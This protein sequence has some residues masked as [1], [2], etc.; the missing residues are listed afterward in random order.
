MILGAGFGT[1]LRPL[2]GQL[3]KPLVPVLNRPLIAYTV[4]KLQAIG[5]SEIVVNL[6]YRGEKLRDYLLSQP[7]DIQFHFSY[8][9]EKILGTAGGLKAAETYLS[10]EEN[11]LLINGDIFFDFDLEEAIKF[12][13]D[14]RAIATLILS[15]YDS[16]KGDF[17]G[18]DSRGKVVRVPGF[19]LS[20]HYSRRGFA[21]IHI[22]TPA[23]FDFLN[24]LPEPPSCIIRTAYLKMLKSELYISSYSIPS[25]KWWDIGTPESL[26][27]LNQELLKKAYGDASLQQRTNFIGREVSISP[28]IELKGGVIVGDGVELKGRGILADTIIFPGLSLELAREYR[29]AIFYREDAPP[30]L[31]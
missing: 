9:R 19:Q 2:T 11:F 3:P 17:I 27:K 21:G 7:W 16:S 14:S 26:F 30:L 6:H 22:L 31:L 29:R 1:R 10:S 4:E 23:I 24:E 8:E 5:I 18:V 20:E 28:D 12:H 15:D 13:R 25:N